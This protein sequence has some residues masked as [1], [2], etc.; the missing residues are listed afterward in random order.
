MQIPEQ[1]R[2]PASRLVTVRGEIPAML[3]GAVDAHSHIWIEP[4]QGAAPDSPIL[5]DPGRIL[6]E[7]QE[8]KAAGGAA[9]IDCQPGGCGRNGNRLAWLSSESGLPVIGCTGFHR[10]R[11]YPPE[12]VLWS[13]DEDRLTRRFVSELNV[14]ME[15]TLTARQPVRAGFV[16]IAIEATLQ[17]TPQAVLAAAATAAVE[18]GA[19]MEIHTEKG[20]QAHQ[21]VDYLLRRGV[22]ASQILI[23]HI[24]KRPDY[25]LHVELARM[26]V[27]LEYDTFY[28]PKYSPES[29]LW[30]LI[31]T[32]VASGMD[33]AMALATDMADSNQWRQY[34]GQPGLAAFPNQIRRRLAERGLTP[35]LIAKMTGGNIL[36]FMAVQPKIPTNME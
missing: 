5:D 23:C 17:D 16:K 21:V 10:R 29:N 20:A 4:V 14:G 6:A 8:Y 33:H 35:D 30:P 18:T 9:I 24:D 26:G 3:T 25:G 22:S 32:M 31:D 19:G 13:Q 15:E 36:R 11:Y 27:M 34:G 12:A 7:L 2:Y 1:A 28:R